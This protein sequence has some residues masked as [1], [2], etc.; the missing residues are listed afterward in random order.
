MMIMV[1][2]VFG[3]AIDRITAGMILLDVGNV[4]RHIGMV[5]EEWFSKV[6]EKYQYLEGEDTKYELR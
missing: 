4:V 1:E 6:Q 3:I 5:H 2:V